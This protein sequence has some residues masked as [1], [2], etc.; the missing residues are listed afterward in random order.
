MS[1]DSKVECGAC[2]WQGDDTHTD[3]GHCPECDGECFPMDVIYGVDGEPDPDGP[4]YQA[5]TND[6]KLE[7]NHEKIE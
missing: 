5:M 2:S 6:T 4:T 1:K 3:S 7:A